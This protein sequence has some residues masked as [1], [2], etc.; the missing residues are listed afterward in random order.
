[1][2]IV[3][4]LMKRLL[5][6]I[7]IHCRSIWN[8]SS[9]LTLQNRWMMPISGTAAMLRTVPARNLSSSANSEV[10]DFDPIL[11]KKM[12]LDEDGILIDCRTQQEFQTGAPKNAIL[13]PYNEIPFRL[14][15]VE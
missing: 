14:D 12:I 1:M 4:G 2:S 6:S 7:R 10:R 13:I 15:E 3:R 8:R 11:A 9:A 5:P